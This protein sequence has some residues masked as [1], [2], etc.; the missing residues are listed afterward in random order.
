MDYIRA[1]QISFNDPDALAE[2]IPGGY[3]GVLPLEKMPFR[4]DL[5]T[6]EL[7]F[8]FLVRNVKTSGAVAIRSELTATWPAIA[9]LLPGL[10]GSSV[11]FDGHEASG[12]TFASR[13]VGHTPSLRTFVPNEVA[14]FTINLDILNQAAEDFA[15]RSGRSALVSPSTILDAGNLDIPRLRAL[16]RAAE[17]MGTYYNIDEVGTDA[18]PAMLLLRDEI[19]AILVQGLVET[20][21]KHDHRARQLQTQSM[22]R[23][24]RYLDEHREMTVGLQDLCHGVNLPLRTVETIIRTRTGLPALIYLRRRRLAFVRNALLNP[25]P[26]TTVTS[27]ALQFGFWH[28][29]RFSQYYRQAYGELPSATILRTSS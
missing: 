24:D 15:G 3:Y 9:Y 6:T 10:D 7:G 1:G 16:H 11:L 20:G 5:R 13:V 21:M 27:A 22:A 14:N 8:G 2:A 19:L 29:G 12:R 25:G 18:P 4:A 23:I 17:E 28:L 26:A